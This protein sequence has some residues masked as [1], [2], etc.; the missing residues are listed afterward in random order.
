MIFN[1]VTYMLFL[2][3]VLALYWVLPRTPRL[4]M[5]FGASILFYGFWR[6]EFVPVMIA[7]ALTDYF[8]ALGISR[9]TRPATRKMWLATSLTVNLS[10]LLYFKYLMFF[11][12][13]AVGLVNAFGLEVPSPALDIILPLGISFYTFQTISYT[14]D[15][16][17]GVIK[18]ERNFI[19]YGCY[20]T[21]FPQ[22]VAGPVLRARE[23]IP[24]LSTRPSFHWLD[25]S[26]G[27]RRDDGGDHFVQPRP[28]FSHSS[29]HAFTD[30]FYPTQ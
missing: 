21:F 17:R 5:I 26:V 24:Q 29:G 25:V 11:A 8:A 13:N 1:S 16:Y 2:S 19:L 4:Y 30:R 20:V 7:S 6:F 12:D 18:P 22:L 28:V 14:V 15:V 27:A 9:T 10:L 3:L 23:V